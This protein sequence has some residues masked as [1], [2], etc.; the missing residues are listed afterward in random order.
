MDIGSYSDDEESVHPLLPPS[1][2][3]D[4]ILVTAAQQEVGHSTTAG[5]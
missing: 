1:R 3:D 5:T 2:G 4:T